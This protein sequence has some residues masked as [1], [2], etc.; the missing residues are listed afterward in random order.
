MKHKFLIMAGGTGG[1]VFPALAVAHELIGRGHEVEW[2]GTAR[3]IES[4]L[5]P[6]TGIVLNIIP[7]EGIRGRGIFGLIK[8][9]LLIAK[10]VMLSRKIIREKNI[11]A[12]I[13]FG[14][15]ASGP[16]AL[17]ART[18]NKPVITHEQ[19]AIAGTT[20]K[21]SSRFAS[22]ILMAFAGAYKNL[23][24]ASVAQVVG[25]PVRQEIINLPAPS[26]RV[27]AHSATTLRLLVVGGS[28]GALAINRLVPQAIAALD[29]QYSVS[30]VHQTGKDHFE[31]TRELYR[32]H[33]VDAE[34]KP[35]IADMASA[36]LQCDLV[37]CRAG[38]LT[39]SELMAAG[40]G[41]I[42]IPLPHAIDDHQTANAKILEAAGAGILLPQSDLDA[43]KLATMIQQQF[44]INSAKVNQPR[45][46]AMGEAA[47]SLS[48][49]QS[50]QLVADAC[51]EAARG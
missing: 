46:I 31:L 26:E 38:A 45:L 32:E 22:R 49:P 35:F 17:A 40:I 20:N 9:P 24:T 10:A 21:L 7:I 3:G 14:G 23:K 27:G 13:G 12:V 2:L 41:A 42:L 11:N 34:V 37:I 39:V 48:I 1:H 18:L 51:E 25:N 19:N 29:S 36:Y 15:F 4:R 8:A 43:Q 47:R 30:I 33:K 5:I 6:E 16:G 50:A 44:F 28:L